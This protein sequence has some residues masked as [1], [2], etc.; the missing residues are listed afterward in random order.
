MTWLKKAGLV[1]LKV[2]GVVTGLEPLLSPYLGKGATATVSKDVNE[3]TS[4]G[5]VVLQAETLI[6]GTGTGATKLAA[7][8]PLV[9]NIVRTSELL[10]G[11]NIANET[12][13]ITACQNL[14][15]A[16]AD[17]LNSLSPDTIKA[18]VDTP[19]AAT[20]TAAPKA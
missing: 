6:Q 16:V 14:T 4:I 5:N 11:K 13:F 7:A 19:A 8:T 12:A 10:T 1:L 18:H 20:T 2:L 15:G 17:I 9:A 3:L